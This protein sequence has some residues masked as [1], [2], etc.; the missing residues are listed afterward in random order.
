[1]LS[2]VQVTKAAPTSFVLKAKAGQI[3]MKRHT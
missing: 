1:M 2:F 3:G